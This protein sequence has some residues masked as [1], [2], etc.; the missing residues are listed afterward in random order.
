MYPRLLHIY[1]PLWI[2]SYGVMIAA[3][4]VLFIGLTLRHAIRKAFISK[5]LFLNTVF[6]GFIGGIVGG[7]LLHVAVNF[8]EF[9]SP[10]QILYPWIP[11][12]AVL[13]SMIGALGFVLLYL[14]KHHIPILPML[15]LAALYG[16]LFQAVARFGCL[17][18]GCCYGC[19]GAGLPWAIMFSRPEGFA[20]LHIPLHPAQL[21]ASLAS[22]IIFILVNVMYRFFRPRFGLLFCYYLIFE[23]A[24]RFVVDFWRGDRGDL[25][26]IIGLNVSIFQIFSFVVGVAA[27]MWAVILYLRKPKTYKSLS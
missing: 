13:G 17:F 6:A 23:N 16:P 2:Y 10:M 24:A 4:F 7:R 14:F 3:G 22:F 19:D 1:G 8:D 26:K 11:G 20:P 18:A 21:Y 25:I 15:D 5:E 9:S 27:F 12:F